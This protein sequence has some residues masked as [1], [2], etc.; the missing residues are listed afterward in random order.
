MRGRKMKVGEKQICFPPTRFISIS[1]MGWVF[2]ISLSQWVY[3]SFNTVSNLSMKSSTFSLVNTN[4][5]RIRRMLVPLQPLKQCCSWMSLLRTS[6]WGM[7]RTVPTIKPRPSP[8]WGVR[9]RRFG[10]LPSHFPCLPIFFGEGSGSN[11][12]LF[13]WHVLKWRVKNEEWRIHQ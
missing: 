9:S 1:F 4:G 2:F 7:S 8:Q 11:F 12:L 13:L 6:L 5:G 10:S 3:T